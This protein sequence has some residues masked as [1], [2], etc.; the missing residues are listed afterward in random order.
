MRLLMSADE[1]VSIRLLA[2]CTLALQFDEALRRCTRQPLP[3]QVNTPFGSTVVS[4]STGILWGNTMD[5]FAQ[6]NK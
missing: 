4:S 3:M 5:D 2:T 1:P 6:P